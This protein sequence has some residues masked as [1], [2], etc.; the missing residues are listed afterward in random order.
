MKCEGIVKILEDYEISPTI[1]REVELYKLFK[2]M[3]R[4]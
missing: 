4:C 3:I 2:H 1:Y